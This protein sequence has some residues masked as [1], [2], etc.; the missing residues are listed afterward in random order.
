MYLFFSIIIDRKRVINNQKPLGG[1]KDGEQW[2]VET[3]PAN[4]FAASCYSIL[5]RVSMPT[6]RK[7]IT[8][9][10]IPVPEE[11]KE[12]P[13]KVRTLHILLYV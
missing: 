6:S 4:L 9:F 8:S 1:K 3:M 13:V 2:T 10:W 11:K 5:Q 7:Q 12:K